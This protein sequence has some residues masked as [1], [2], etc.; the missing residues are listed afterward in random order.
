MIVSRLL[1]T[2][3]QAELR[4]RHAV[5][6]ELEACEGLVAVIFRQ[7]DAAIAGAKRGAGGDAE[8]IR[9]AERRP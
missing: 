6:L 3:L 5:T 4:D 9:L 8:V 7:A 2:A 1:A